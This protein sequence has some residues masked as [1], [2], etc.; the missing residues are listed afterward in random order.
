MKA[1]S[2]L[3]YRELARRRLP[4]FLFEY[5]DGGSYDERTLQ[6]NVAVTGT[7]TTKSSLARERWA[8]WKL[9]ARHGVPGGLY[10][11]PAAMPAATPPD[12]TP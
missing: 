5:I 1:A 8:R 3:D 4:K 10:T 2:V 9:L 7:E 11:A 6:R 12:G